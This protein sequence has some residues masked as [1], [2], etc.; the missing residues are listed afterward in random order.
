M[1][2]LRY[3]S[4]TFGS[5]PDWRTYQTGLKQGKLRR[6]KPKSTVRR[7]AAAAV[8]G[9]LLYGLYALLPIRLDILQERWSTPPQISDS[10]KGTSRERAADSG[11]GVADS[12]APPSGNAA[13]P[14]PSASGSPSA[15]GMPPDP[16]PEADAPPAPGPSPEA[17]TAVARN[18]AENAYASDSEGGVEASTPVIDKAV[19]QL[20]FDRRRF[21]NL[22]K[23]AFDYDF[24]GRRYHIDT[25]IDPRLQRHMITSLQPQHAHSIGIVVMEPET[26]RILAMVSHNRDNPN[27]NACT[28]SLFPAASIFKIVTAAAAVEEYGLQPDSTVTYVGAKH[29][30]YRSQI[31]RNNQQN[32]NRISLR[33]SFAQ[34]VNPVF[35]KLGAQYLGKQGLISHAEAF[36]FN[37]EIDFEL[38]MAP[39]SVSVSDEPYNWA[40]IASGFNRSTMLSPLHGAIM[41]SAVVA[42]QGRLIEPSLVDR[43]TDSSGRV[44][45][46]GQ[47]KTLNKALSPETSSAMQALMKETVL[48]GTCRKSFEGISR[49]PILS[50]LNIGGKSGSINSRSTERR[51]FDWFVGYAEEK[52]GN[53]KIVLSI[54]VAHQNY[55]GTKANMYAR[56]AIEKYFEDAGPK[57]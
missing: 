23:R 24:D 55:I 19:I 10:G 54:V 27:T 56:K 11:P 34:S 26:G 42:N 31:K 21:V 48:T 39:S 47:T 53:R 33:D 37:Q 8:M 13:T 28:E 9:G 35:G 7:I 32:A 40:E 43:I 49:S 15:S 18:D 41:A 6:R 2:R 44:I 51:R 12:Q 57:I 29:T 45:Y 5:R 14:L 4:G 25:S 36:G 16:A 38:P 50:R 17:E 1:Q 20:L 3:G 30:L 46:R 52:Q 22:S